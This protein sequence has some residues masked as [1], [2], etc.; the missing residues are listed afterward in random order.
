MIGG[1]TKATE[2]A[3]CSFSSTAGITKRPLVALKQTDWQL[4]DRVTTSTVGAVEMDSRAVAPKGRLNHLDCLMVAR[5]CIAVI[6][7]GEVYFE[8]VVKC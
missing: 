6:F 5:C 8:R 4:S 2:A 7:S 3:A 1:L